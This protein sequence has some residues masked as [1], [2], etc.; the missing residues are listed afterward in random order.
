MLNQIGECIKREQ[1]LIVA[2]FL[3]FLA[4]NFSSAQNL[5][6]NEIMSSNENT[7]KDQEGEFNDWI[8]LYNATDKPVNLEGYGLSDAK[9][10]LSKWTFP[11]LEIQGKGFL[12]VWAS[13]KDIAI[14]GELHANFSLSSSGEEVVLTDANNVIIDEI[15]FGDIPKDHSYGRKNEG[16]KELVIFK[17][18]TPGLGNGSGK[19]IQGFTPKIVPSIPSGFYAKKTLVEFSLGDHETSVYYTTD[20]SLP[21]AGSK[22]LTSPL[23]INNRTE[24]ANYFSMIPTTH[25]GGARGY[26][27]PVGKVAKGTVI[28]TMAVKAGYEPTYQ[29]FSYFVF[30][31]GGNRYSLPVFSIITEEKNLFS[32]ETGLFVPGDTYDESDSKPQYT[33]NYF[34]RG[35]EWERPIDIFYFDENGSLGFQE[36]AGLRI[37]GGITRHFPQKALRIYFRSD[38]GSNSIDYPLFDNKNYESKE[39]RRFLLRASGNDFGETYFRDAF[40]HQLVSHLDIDFQEYEPSIVFV[41]GEY[42]GIHN[43]RERQDKYY[44]NNLYGVNPENVDLLT[45]QYTVKE[46]DDVQYKLIL[47]LLAKLDPSDENSIK[48]LE[49]YIDLSN[50]ID[51][52]IAQIYFANTDWP[53]NNI[54]FWRERTDYAADKPKGRDGRFRWMLYDTDHGLSHVNEAEHNTLDWVT[55]ELGKE[56]WVWPNV[57]F[58]SLLAHDIYKERFINRYLDLLNTGFK[59]NRAGDLL[60]KMKDKIGPEIDEHLNRWIEPGSKG[61]WE[62]EV[63]E[64]KG[65]I[66]ERPNNI[67]DQLKRQFDVGNTYRVKLDISLPNSGFI[68]INSVEVNSRTP[69]VD[70]VPYPWEGVYFD[71]F[72]IQVSAKPKEGYLFDHWIING[73]VVEKEELEIELTQD[74]EIKAFFTLDP[75]VKRRPVYFWFFGT[76]IENDVALTEVLPAY[77][78][79][80]SGAK[81]TF[82]PAISPYPGADTRGIMDRVNDP[83]SINFIDGLVAE[84]DDAHYSMD[85]MRGLRVR[86][87]LQVGENLAHLIL[88]APMTI[89]DKPKFSAAVLRTNNGPASILV[90]YRK[91]LDEEWTT[92]GMSGFRF[93]LDTEYQLIEVDFEGIRG[94]TANPEFQIKIAFEGNTVEDSGNV[95]FNNMAIEAYEL[96]GDDL[97]TSLPGIPDKVSP[98]LVKKAYPNPTDGNVY[99][100]FVD[101]AAKKINSIEVFDL[102][103]VEIKRIENIDEKV[104]VINFANLQSGMYIIRINSILRTETIKIFKR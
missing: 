32:D 25:H 49:R 80:H 14:G 104:D 87:P 97:V 29:S 99:L 15:V 72:P 56:D 67:I 89:Y 16:N 71:K 76:D 77:R 86:N 4:T 35:D 20:G 60:R 26:Q 53:H 48:E 101:E 9:S 51:Y 31:E 91:S 78:R 95:R 40:A 70:L 44:L 22:Q 61:D 7:H 90:S 3:L 43:I 54:D 57:V 74:T 94:I 84:E 62:K 23:E 36:G 21:N 6:I 47:D 52:M 81:L 66:T 39:I 27:T 37:H 41:N 18:P 69:G 59:P 45:H 85:E 30:P 8:E 79:N 19:Y 64:I 5:V 55:G 93:D 46:G 12:L 28:R 100:E 65:F 88:D 50:H 102:R 58:R 38:Y 34:Q 83:T 73:K 17:E 2:F 98:S 24:E 92:E 10:E 75:I 103:G 13:G 96:T 68:K 1:R 11:S 42:W 63:E 82:F 33:G